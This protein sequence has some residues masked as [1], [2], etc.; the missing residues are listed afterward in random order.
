MQVSPYLLVGTGGNLSASG[1]FEINAGDA[2]QKFA[3]DHVPANEILNLRCLKTLLVN[4]D[5]KSGDKKGYVNVERFGNIL[6][7]FGPLIKKKDRTPFLDAVRE[8]LQE[9]WFHGYLFPRR[10]FVC[11]VSCRVS[12]DRVLMGAAVISRRARRRDGST[13]RVR[14]AS[15]CG[16]RPTLPTLAASP[17]PRCPPTARSP[18]SVRSSLS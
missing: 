15:W 10:Y 4:H 17:S 9:A 5:N 6:N 13:A 18:T 1:E 14:G 11:C 3:E 7:W 12:C 8:I 16:S 2:S